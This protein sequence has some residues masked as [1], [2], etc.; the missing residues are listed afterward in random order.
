VDFDV[1]KV[2]SLYYFSAEVIL[3]Q[4]PFCVRRVVKEV[5]MGQDYSVSSVH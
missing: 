5:A 1:P 3:F 2:V 4:G